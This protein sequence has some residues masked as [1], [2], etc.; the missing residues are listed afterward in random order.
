MLEP[1]P[2]APPTAADALPAPLRHGDAPGHKALDVYYGPLPTRSHLRQSVCEGQRLKHGHHAPATQGSIDLHRWTLTPHGI[3]SR[4]R[5]KPS[6]IG[7]AVGD[8]IE[9]PMR[10]WSMR[11]GY[12]HSRMDGA[13]SPAFQA[14]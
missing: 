9:T 14:E 6:P 5:A 7:Q 3:H 1:N 10:T 2:A 4:E 11:H 13:C 12:S 8:H